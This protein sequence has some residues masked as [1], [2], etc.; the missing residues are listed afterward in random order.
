MTTGCGKMEFNSS[1]SSITPSGSQPRRSARVF[2][3]WL[4]SFSITSGM[5]SPTTRS[6]QPRQRQ[7]SSGSPQLAQTRYISAVR[8]WDALMPTAA[9]FS[10]PLAIRGRRSKERGSTQADATSFRTLFNQSALSSFFGI[11]PNRVATASAEPIIPALRSWA[12]RRRRS[13]SSEGIQTSRSRATSR[14]AAARWTGS[15]SSRSA[16]CCARRSRGVVPGWMSFS[17]LATTSWA[18]SS[19]VFPFPRTAW[20]SANCTG[21]R[22]PLFRSSSETSSRRTG[23]R[24]RESFIA[25]RYERMLTSYAT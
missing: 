14:P 10:M 16:R 25:A 20:S 2:V 11:F 3:T 22:R 23:M 1:S 4:L 17:S 7:V 24:S 13:F 9:T 6:L 21:E 18:I 8:S 5:L 12:A 15:K 19:A